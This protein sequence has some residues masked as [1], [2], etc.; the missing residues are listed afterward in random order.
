ME[1]KAVLYFSA[2]LESFQEDI[3][4]IHNNISMKLEKNDK[5]IFKGRYIMSVY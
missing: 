1:I 4:Y 2:L 3:V 5:E